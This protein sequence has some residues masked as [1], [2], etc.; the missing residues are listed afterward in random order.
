M[1]TTIQFFAATS[2]GPVHRFCASIAEAERL[3][4]EYREFTTTES[5]AVTEDGSEVEWLSWSAQDEQ[6]E[7]TE[8]TARIYDTDGTD[9]SD[10]PALR[11]GESLED[12]AYRLYAHARREI[13]AS[14][15][16][17]DVE[18]LLLVQHEHEASVVVYAETADEYVEY[19]LLAK[20]VSY[21][22]TAQEWREAIAAASAD[23][24]GQ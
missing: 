18:R 7:T 15:S 12:Y 19:C 4:D 21:E 9:W 1:T 17:G 5:V 8:I 23:Q 11:A 14:S 6:D 24:D 16:Y 20:Q 2:A 3:C 22:A 10:L 13:L